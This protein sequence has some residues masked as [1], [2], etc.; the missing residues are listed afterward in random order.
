M[1][2]VEFHYRIEARIKLT[3]KELRILLNSALNHYDGV[4]Q[5]SAKP[6]GFLYGMKNKFILDK[7]VDDFGVV[8]RQLLEFNDLDDQVCEYTL[9]SHELDTLCKIAEQEP[10]SGEPLVGLLY[11][12]S[13]MMLRVNQEYAR[14]NSTPVITAVQGV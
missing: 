6:G 8:Q 3:G 7:C 14:A 5:Q 9:T 10:R 13:Q 2:F 11:P 4:C 1:E 12:L